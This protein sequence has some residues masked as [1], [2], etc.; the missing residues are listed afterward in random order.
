MNKENAASGKAKTNPKKRKL[1]EMSRTPECTEEQKNDLW[2]KK[3]AP[4]SIV[5][6]ITFIPSL[7]LY[8]TN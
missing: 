8:R 3:Y 5:K 1:T 2:I 4:Q 7:R 6:L